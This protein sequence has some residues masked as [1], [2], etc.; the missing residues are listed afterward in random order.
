M[1]RAAAVVAT[2]MAAAT[3]F[4]AAPAQAKP[5]CWDPVGLCHRLCEWGIVC[6][7]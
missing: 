1:K 4:F 5:L 7:R 2:T 6:S 3:I